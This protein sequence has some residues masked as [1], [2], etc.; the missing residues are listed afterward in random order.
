MPPVVD[1][2]AACEMVYYVKGVAR[3]VERMSLLGRSCLLTY[4]EGHAQA[5]DPHF[6]NLPGC[7]RFRFG[8]VEWIAVWWRNEETR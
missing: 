8:E 2:V 4:Y 7:E 6:A 5:L 1:L 3:F